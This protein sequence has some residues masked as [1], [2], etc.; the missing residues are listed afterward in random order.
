M[1]V[2]FKIYCTIPL[3]AYPLMPRLRH[4]NKMS[5]HNV[6]WQCFSL[7][8]C[9]T[10]EVVFARREAGRSNQYRQTNLSA[11]I[12][13]ST[14]SLV[15]CSTCCPRWLQCLNDR[16]TC[17]GAE[18]PEREVI[19]ITR[20]NRKQEQERELAR[21]R[22]R[23]QVHGFLARSGLCGSPLSVKRRREGSCW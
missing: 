20:H 15:L 5:Q 3:L 1:A 9:H 7:Q 10:E 23:V 16:F 19:Q 8:R 17:S 12:F 22:A 14:N 18:T 13:Q 21:Q 2:I 6:S 4:K 11:D